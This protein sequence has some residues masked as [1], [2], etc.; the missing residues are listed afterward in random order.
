MNEILILGCSFSAGDELADPDI[1][2]DAYW[3]YLNE[4]KEERQKRINSNDY[5]DWM[6]DIL[7]LYK[8]DREK[9]VDDC[10]KY[11]WGTLLQEKLK[12]YKI[13]NY[14]SGGIGISLYQYLYNN[15]I[16]AYVRIP[17]YKL[18]EK[19]NNS[20][21]LIWQITLEPRY[22]FVADKEIVTPASKSFGVENIENMKINHYKKKIIKDYFIHCVN[23]F[24]IYKK[25]I[26]FANYIALKRSSEK[27]KTIFFSFFNDDF[28]QVHKESFDTIT[29]N[30]YVHYVNDLNEYKGGLVDKY[31]KEKIIS[32]EK[33][34]L[35]F[36]HPN[37]KIQKLVAKDIYDFLCDNG[38]VE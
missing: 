34:Y 19:I 2:G 38:V 8:G 21:I 11:V 12:D 32:V 27:K 10:Q 4:S 33:D 20:D 9:Y 26:N 31:H 30:P 28:W 36:G 17:K 18:A 16:Y 1:F 22:T 24:E 23:P 5:R 35:R 37:H 6:S 15:P 14:A 29:D 3:D 7:K 25:N 13:I